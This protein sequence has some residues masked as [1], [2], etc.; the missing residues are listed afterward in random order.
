MVQF[1]IVDILSDDIPNDEGGKDFLVTIYGKT[2]DNKSIVCN[3]IGFKPYFY[4]KIPKKWTNQRVEIFLREAG[5]NTTNDKTIE[6]YVT[7]YNKHDPKN[8]ILKIKES[9]LID[10]TELYGFKC[11]SDGSV[12]TYNFVKLEFSSHTAMSKYS[13]AIRKKYSLLK[14]QTDT[15]YHK[16]FKEWFNLDKDDVCDSHLYESNIHPSIRFIHECHIQPANWISVEVVDT[17]AHMAE[18]Y[19]EKTVR[20]WDIVT[21]NEKLVCFPIGG[22]DEEE[23]EDQTVRD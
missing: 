17:Y 4:L 18:C 22:E 2:S 1:Q 9:N 6:S 12:L 11:H 7:G 14:R 13:E 23:P 15:K 8:D 3:A 20:D 10:F 19:Y 21:A 5:D 16:L